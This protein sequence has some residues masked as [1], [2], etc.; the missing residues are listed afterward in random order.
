[1]GHSPTIAIRDFTGEV[2]FDPAAPEQA[3]LRMQIR[4]DSLEVTDDISGKDRQ[5]NGEHDE[6]ESAGKLEV[7]RRSFLR[8]LER[9]RTNWAKDDTRSRSTAACRCTA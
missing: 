5:G 4:A 1:M 6:S 2:N 8:A 9:P 3:S 7:S